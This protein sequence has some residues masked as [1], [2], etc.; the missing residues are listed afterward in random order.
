MCVSSELPPVAGLYDGFLEWIGLSSSGGRLN[1]A[2]ERKT[3]R[4]WGRV[5]FDISVNKGK[6]QWEKTDQQMSKSILN[7]RPHLSVASLDHVNTMTTSY[8][9]THPSSPSP[10]SH[11]YCRHAHT[12]SVTPHYSHSVVSATK[13]I[14][15]E[16]L[17]RKT[18]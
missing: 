10:L 18:H 11:T 17:S 5:G 8:C 14:S 7:K 12:Y 4:E 6:E 15:E 16:H 9:E 2:R 3:T 13:A 1:R